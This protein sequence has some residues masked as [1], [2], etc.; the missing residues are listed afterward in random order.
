MTRVA[1]VP[2]GILAL[3]LTACSSSV[4]S[5]PVSDSATSAPLASVPPVTESAGDALLR[6]QKQKLEDIRR[7]YENCK[8]LADYS[9]MMKLARARRAELD[10]VIRRVHRMKLSPGEHERILNPLRQERD[11][12][13]QVI[14]AASAM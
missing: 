1:V 14:Q 9:R 7:E 10:A 5:E 12:H 3:M 11:W 4:P 2:I 13:L 8:D 6:E